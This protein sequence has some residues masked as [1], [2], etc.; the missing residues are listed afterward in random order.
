MF[1]LISGQEGEGVCWSGPI[2]ITL[3][4]QVLPA[5]GRLSCNCYRTHRSCSA[6][7]I[8]MNYDADNLKIQSA[9]SILIVGGPTGVELARLSRKQGYAGSCLTM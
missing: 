3:P 8:D 5:D 1:V 7:F 2:E 6:H 4:M 9:H